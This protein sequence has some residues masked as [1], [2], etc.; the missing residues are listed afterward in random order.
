MWNLYCYSVEKLFK[1][2]YWLNTF[3][4]LCIFEFAN[5]GEHGSGKTIHTSEMSGSDGVVLYVVS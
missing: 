3:V 5:K 4:T 1:L 2:N